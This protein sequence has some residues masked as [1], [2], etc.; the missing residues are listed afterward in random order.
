M[1]RDGL[2]DA[3]NHALPSFSSP[4]RGSRRLQ[5]VAQQT[6]YLVAM[7]TGT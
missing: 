5:L 2:R 4:G 1:R 3:L 6:L 7:Q